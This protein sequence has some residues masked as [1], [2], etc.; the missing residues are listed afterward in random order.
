VHEEHCRRAANDETPANHH[1]PLSGNFNT[2]MIEQR[3]AG[4]GGTGGEAR[5][6]TGGSSGSSGGPGK[7]RRLRAGGDA[8]KVFGRVQGGTD[9]AF[10]DMGGKGAEEQRPLDSGIFVYGL[11]QGHKFVLS[12]ILRQEMALYRDARRIRPLYQALFVS[13]IAIPA[14]QP[15]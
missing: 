12:G 9:G 5:R 1:D 10:V 7:N 8:V 13:N 3:D 2:V 4:L 6:A 14:P 15:D 11:D